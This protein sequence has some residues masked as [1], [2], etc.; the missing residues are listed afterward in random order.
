MAGVYTPPFSVLA[1]S[2]LGGFRWWFVGRRTIAIVSSVG[3][4][5]SMIFSLFPS[6][7]SVLESS[8]CFFGLSVA[9]VNGNA[10]SMTYN[11]A[12]V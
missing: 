4:L 10:E 6:S 9:F 2:M 5:A 12:A 11:M 1:M 7:V 3:G 8:V